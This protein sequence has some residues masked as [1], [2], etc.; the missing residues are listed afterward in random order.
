MSTIDPSIASIIAR[1]IF[2]GAMFTATYAGAIMKNEL[3]SAD[4]K[5]SYLRRL[6]IG[7]FAG[8]LCSS[9]ISIAV[10]YSLQAAVHDL[11]EVKYGVEIGEGISKAIAAFF[12]IDLCIKIPKWFGISNYVSIDHLELKFSDKT[13]FATSLFWNILRE[14]AEA[15]VLTAVAVVLSNVKNYGAAIGIGVVAAVLVGG[16]IALGAKYLNRMFFSLLAT[17]MLMML[18]TGLCVG[19]VYALEEAYEIKSGGITSGI[20]YKVSNNPERENI[21]KAF[22][23]CGIR[24]TLTVAACVTWVVVVFL[25]CFVQIWHNYLGYD[26]I[27]KFI[28][29]KFAP[30]TSS[31][32]KETINDNNNEDEEFAV[33][34]GNNI[35]INPSQNV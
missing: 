23:W 15:G 29:E 13:V 7:L 33:K 27:P 14:G 30:S 8:L 34:K 5:T 26:I 18:S 35:L 19:A 11:K 9:I 4:E 6:I 25:L 32:P 2:E 20:V 28:Q 22:S 3:L 1:E 31:S 17:V 16:P 10:G 12:V 24:K 21:L